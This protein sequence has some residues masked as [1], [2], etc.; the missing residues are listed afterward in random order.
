MSVVLWYHIHIHIL[1]HHQIGYS[2]R[3]ATPATTSR[4]TTYHCEVTSTFCIF[5][6][7][8]ADRTRGL[9]SSV[10]SFFLAD[11]DDLIRE[12]TRIS[13]FSRNLPI[14]VGSGR[15]GS[16]HEVRVRKIT[17]RVGSGQ[18]GRLS[19]RNNITLF[20]PPALV[21]RQHVES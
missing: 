14:W 15:V 16:G 6:C 10:W 1:R 9:K 19:D 21:V 12:V 11:Q 4:Q 20:V 13:R 5:R 7:R 3:P 18:I 17:G 2:P 8:P